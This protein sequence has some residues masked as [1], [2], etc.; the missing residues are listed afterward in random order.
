MAEW[1]DQRDQ[2]DRGD[3]C[4]GAG[5]EVLR[6][7]YSGREESLKVGRRRHEGLEESPGQRAPGWTGESLSSCRRE[8]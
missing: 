1:Q 5:E 8:H 2:G 4:L 7:H 6:H 3:Y